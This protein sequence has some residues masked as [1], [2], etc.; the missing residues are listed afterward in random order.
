[1]YGLCCIKI[2]WSVHNQNFLR[3]GT[4][5]KTI[6]NSLIYFVGLYNFALLITI[7]L[8]KS[9]VKKVYKQ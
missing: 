3:N 1:M 7:I 8:L 6:S 4:L 2:D 5:Y 9:I